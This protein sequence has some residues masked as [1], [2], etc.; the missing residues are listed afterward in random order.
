M[1][2]TYC[3]VRNGHIYTKDESICVCSVTEGDWSC[4]CNRAPDDAPSCYCFGTRNFV[5]V[6]YVLEDGDLDAYCGSFAAMFNSEANACYCALNEKYSFATVATAMKH[7]AIWKSKQE[8]S[9]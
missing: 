9:Q 5:V 8:I 7:Y 4:D 6:D 2:L 1:K 3:D